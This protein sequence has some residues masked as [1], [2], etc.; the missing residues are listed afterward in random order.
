MGSGAKK[1][2][3]SRLTLKRE[4]DE[5][6]LTTK[7]LRMLRLMPNAAH[8]TCRV[9][10]ARV[11]PILVNGKAVEVD[12]DGPDGRHPAELREGYG[13]SHVSRCH[14]DG[15]RRINSKFTSNNT[16]NDG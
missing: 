8:G 15:P 11:Y 1:E 7:Q 9:C 5:F 12:C 16:S 13:V 14:R 3:A 6:V 10:G 2:A 4:K